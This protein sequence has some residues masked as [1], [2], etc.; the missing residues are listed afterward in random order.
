[1]LNNFGLQTKVC[2]HFFYKQLF[3]KQHQAE[4]NKKLRKSEATP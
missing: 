1:M 4:I 2:T 3:C